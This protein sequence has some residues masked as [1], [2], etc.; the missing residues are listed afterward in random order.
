MITAIN[1][2]NLNYQPMIIPPITWLESFTTYS[3]KGHKITQNHNVNFLCYFFTVHGEF[4]CNKFQK[5]AN[6]TRK[7]YHR[8]QAAGWWQP[9]EPPWIYDFSVPCPRTVKRE[10]FFDLCSNINFWWK[11]DFTA[12]WTDSEC[13][14]VWIWMVDLVDFKLECILQELEVY[15]K[16][17]KI[18]LMTQFFFIVLKM[19]RFCFPVFM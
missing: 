15:W 9:C 19:E 11:L 16:W 10:K 12:R 7:A 18:R 1:T 2:W 13:V 3:V 14:C 6:I 8:R 5:V 4:C 17:F